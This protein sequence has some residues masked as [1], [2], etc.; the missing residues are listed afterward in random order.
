M[1][2]Q[3]LKKKKKIVNV[4]SGNNITG[5]LISKE[6]LKFFT[7]NLK[8]LVLR[9]EEIYSNIFN[10]WKGDLTIFNPIKNIVDEIFLT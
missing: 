9:V 6:E 4:F 5:V 3:L 7:H 1:Q 8:K 10:N 2:S